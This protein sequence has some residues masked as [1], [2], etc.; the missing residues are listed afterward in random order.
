M[1]ISRN[2]PPR[3][4]SR[5][6]PGR[7]KAAATRPEH[8]PPFPLPL[9]PRRKVAAEAM[10][11]A[12]LRLPAPSGTPKPTRQR[13]AAA[14]QNGTPV[15]SPSSARNP[16]GPDSLRPP[17]SRTLIKDSRGSVLRQQVI[18]QAR[19]RARAA[20]G[21][22]GASEPPSSGRSKTFATPLH[23]DENTRLLRDTTDC[24]A[25]DM[26]LLP[27]EYDEAQPASNILT[28][29]LG[30]LQGIAK[31]AVPCFTEMFSHARTLGEKMDRRATR[32][33]QSIGEGHEEEDAAQPPSS[34]RSQPA[35]REQRAKRF[36]E[37]AEIAQQK[38]R[39]VAAA[40]RGRAG[41]PRTLGNHIDPLRRTGDMIVPD[42]AVVVAGSWTGTVVGRETGTV[43]GASEFSGAG[44]A[45]QIHGGGA[46]A[47]AGLVPTVVDCLAQLDTALAGPAR[48]A[49]AERLLAQNAEGALRCFKCYLH[50][51]PARERDVA[52][53]FNFLE[54]GSRIPRF[55][56]K[57][58]YLVDRTLR[59]NIRDG[60]LQS[61]S[62]LNGTAT[63]IITMSGNA[64]PAGI[65][66]L[67]F[68][69]A[70]A[71]ADVTQSRMDKEYFT[72]QADKAGRLI[73]ACDT[74]KKRWALPERNSPAAHPEEEKQLALVV[75]AVRSQQT[76]LNR[77]NKREARMTGA[78]L[79]KGIWAP[80][81]A[82]ASSTVA[83]LI[84]GGVIVTSIPTAGG[85]TAALALIGPLVYLG[86][87]TYKHGKRAA[88]A[89]NEKWRRRAAEIVIQTHSRTA[90]EALI[91][92]DAVL[93]LRVGRGD[94]VGAMSRHDHG[95]AGSME[96]FLDT[97]SN[98]YIGLHLL[99]LGLR[100]MLRNAPGTTPERKRYFA[101]LVMLLLV[102]EV[103]PL[104]LHLILRI[105]QS[106]L[107][108][109]LDVVPLLKQHLAPYLGLQFDSADTPHVS[110]MLSAFLARWNQ[111]KEA[112]DLPVFLERG[113][114]D[115][116][117]SSSANV[118]ARQVRDA[119][120]RRIYANMARH[121]DMALFVRKVKELGTWVESL[122]MARTAMSQL[123]LDGLDF[124]RF[125]ERERLLG[126][127]AGTGPTGK[128]SELVDLEQ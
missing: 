4:L 71:W 86:A 76:R 104:M 2:P 95:F 108:N 75:Y 79:F 48:V 78:M 26:T 29:D 127:R 21:A 122:D 62:A 114:S 1:D 22:S 14:L 13:P 9:T 73:E 80:P 61:L 107:E 125:I 84:V 113:N 94:F 101:R 100:D 68:T 3:D 90:L 7:R 69:F 34:P 85:T 11:D 109:G 89:S 93:H 119:A 120:F 70:S 123:A 106:G 99:A 87:T 32:A 112:R 16:D 35:R 103:P 124:V 8:A 57:A 126:K 58:K 60:L 45:A 47:F 102:C 10:R 65:I 23:D 88:A 81:A 128:D 77:R 82:L 54:A 39:A 115:P 12:S 18:E 44:W 38:S 31:A 33:L 50:G 63:H 17:P 83:V 96:L 19:A 36:N 92:S 111:E 110:V 91:A 53:L 40:V 41:L 25:V 5:S 64:S 66:L 20:G 37:V 118:H 117:S 105:A 74:L 116:G 56:D 42:T 72:D 121:V 98:E 51:K 46:F 28:L 43:A 30:Y 24:A 67:P 49:A 97:R 55:S 59:G 15:T 27:G 6:D 52:A